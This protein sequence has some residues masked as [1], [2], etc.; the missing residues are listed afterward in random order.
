MSINILH[1]YFT[2]AFIALIIM[3]YHNLYTGAYIKNK[4]TWWIIGFLIILAG[5]RNFAPDDIA[6]SILYK[7]FGALLS[8]RL[9]D[10]EE[11]MYGI[12]WLYVVYN[13]IIYAIGF[14]FYMFIVITAVLIIP[15][16]YKFFE[17]NSPYPALS[18]MIYMIPTYFVGDITH[19]RQSI[20]VAIVFISFYTIKHRKW[21]LFLALIYLAKGFHN[22]SIIFIF[23]YWLVLFP[24]NRWMIIL[25]VGICMALSPFNIYEQIPMLNSIVPDDVMQGF[26]NYDSIVDE[27]SGTIKLPDLI[28]LFYLYFIVTYDKEACQ[29]IPYYEYM[30]NLTIAGICIYFIFRSSPIFSTRLV[31]YYFLFGTITIPS[32][33]SSIQNVNLRKGLY[34]LTTFYIIFYFFVFSAMQGKRAYS[35]ETYSNW[36]IGG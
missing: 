25:I 29:K 10:M 8:F 15:I 22:S 12:E 1:P 21:W 16:K 34:S 4:H 27:N 19:I 23:A 26:E 18:F 31:S 35:P 7:E 14:P 2:L 20:A 17:N 9:Q 30:R 3:S 32:I 24:L 13:K 5:F 28:S 6:Y 33:I 11:N 36:L